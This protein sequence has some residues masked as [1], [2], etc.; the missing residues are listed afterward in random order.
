[1]PTAAEIVAKPSNDEKNIIGKLE[2]KYNPW[3]DTQNGQFTHEGQGARYGTGGG[4]F[5]GGGASGSWD[6]PK[7]KPSVGFGG[8]GTSGSWNKPKAKPEKPK[9][10]QIGSPIA[11]PAKPTLV[12]TAKS[13]M[14]KIQANGYHFE[15]DEQNRTVRARGEL[16][17]D[18]SQV[19]DPTAQRDGGKPDRL[20]SDHGGHF[21]GRQFG[22]PKE[23]INLFAQDANFNRS[24][25]AALENEWR[26]NLNAGRKVEVDIQA[27]YSRRSKRPDI[28]DVTY[29]IDGKRTPQR[30]P[31]ASRKG[32]R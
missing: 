30:F 1:M 16:R 15:L 21:I 9:R 6:K 32:K 11:S 12:T 27:Y 19:R 17:L 22:G 3:H 23:A 18:N 14:R 26:R 29:Y 13:R 4:S 5:G 28:I 24:G 2:L 8:G 20:G 7:T 25:Y 10:E 31:N